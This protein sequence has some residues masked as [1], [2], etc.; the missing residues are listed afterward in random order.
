M[1]RILLVE[2]DP[3]S[4]ELLCALLTGSG[5]QV[6]PAI[7]LRA[8]RERLQ[9]SPVDLVVL[10]LNL[11]DG[12]GFALCTEIRAK[13]SLPVLILSARGGP[14]DRVDG[15]RLGADDFLS[16][17]YAPRELLARI[18]AIGRRRDWTSSRSPIRVGP[19]YIEP[20]KRQVLLDQQPISLTETEFEILLVLAERAGRA[21]SRERLSL[22]ARGAGWGAFDR[23]LDVHVSRIRKKL[24]TETWIRSVRGV[25]YLLV[26]Q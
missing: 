15:L 3:R 16:K 13:G 14:D 7:T 1:A 20:G 18:D 25:G 21:V 12:D 11:P 24:G 9:D 17:P 6:V 26:S 19:L 10:D 8:A 4:V 5:H 2:D 23:T 22:L